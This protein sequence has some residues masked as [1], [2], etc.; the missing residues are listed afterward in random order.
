MEH[1]Y[2]SADM[3]LLGH[4]HQS[5]ILHFERGGKE[6]IACIGGTLKQYEDY[7]RKHGI[8]GRAGQPGICVSLW[9]DRQEMQGY[10]NFERAVTEHVR[11]L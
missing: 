6:R 10:K 4:T 2:P 8:G 1:E 7:A 9:P 3:I 5:E 11:R